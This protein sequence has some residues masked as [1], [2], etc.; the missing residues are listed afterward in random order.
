[1]IDHSGFHVSDIEKSKAFYEKAL[2]PLGYAVI[3]EFPEWKVVGLGV[4]GK[5][6]FWLV[7]DG[8]DHPNH[9]AFAA[10]SKEVVDAFY[11]AGIANGGTDN[12]APGYRQNYTAG[13]YA[14][15][16]KDVDGHNVEAVFHDPNPS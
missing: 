16:V 5:S 9:I 15:F 13:Y 2:A 7:G 1:M 10:A 11:T 14:A 6:D 3:S 4:G 8:A 12:G